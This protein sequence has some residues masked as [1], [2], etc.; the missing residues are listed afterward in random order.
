VHVHGTTGWSAAGSR[1]RFIVTARSLHKVTK[2][3]MR[4]LNTECASKHRATSTVQRA[5]GWT[6]ASQSHFI[7][8]SYLLLPL[9]DREEGRFL[10]IRHG[11]RRFLSAKIAEVPRILSV[12]RFYQTASSRGCLLAGSCMGAEVPGFLQFAATSNACLGG[13]GILN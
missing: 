1:G 7:T 11:V 9:R 6:T 4:R 3:G 5:S 12:S 8:V 13:F 10:R 2:C